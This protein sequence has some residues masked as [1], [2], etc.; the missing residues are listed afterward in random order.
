MNFSASPLGLPL[1]VADPL[2]CVPQSFSSGLF[3]YSL[4]FNLC[5]LPVSTSAEWLPVCWDCKGSND[6]D[7]VKNLFLNF[8]FLFFAV[9]SDDYLLEVNAK[10][11]AILLLFSL[12]NLSSLS[13]SLFPF[14]R[15]GVQM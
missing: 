8:F 4:C 3:N 10:R 6:F 5:Y 15:S 13:L 2:V 14:L 9:S 11:D 7:I 12:S 1:Y